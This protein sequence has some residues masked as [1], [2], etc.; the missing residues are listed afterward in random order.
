MFQKKERKNGK[1][2]GKN[3]KSIPKRYSAIWCNMINYL[4]TNFPGPVLGNSDMM[5]MVPVIGE[6]TITRREKQANQMMT[7]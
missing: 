2:I 6:F 4:G 5:E 1:S 7:T 3:G